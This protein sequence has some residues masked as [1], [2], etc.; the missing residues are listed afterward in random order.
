M[1]AADRALFDVTAWDMEIALENPAIRAGNCFSVPVA[2][3][4]SITD[5][6]DIAPLMPDGDDL[7][8]RDDF[9][10]PSFSH[11]DAT[12]EDHFWLCH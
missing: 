3:F 11:R 10:R 2:L 9:L 8:R 12:V 5:A 1:P 4:I 6:R 7:L